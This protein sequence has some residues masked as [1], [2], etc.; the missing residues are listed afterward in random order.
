MHVCIM[1]HVHMCVSCTS[2]CVMK[3]AYN[4]YILVSIPISL[5]LPRYIQPFHPSPPGCM[6]VDLT[7]PN[8]HHVPSTCR[9]GVCTGKPVVVLIPSL[10]P[11]VPST[12]S[13]TC[14]TT[15]NTCIAGYAPSY[16]SY[17]DNCPC[18][19]EK[20]SK[21]STSMQH[22]CAAD[23]MNTVD[24]ANDVCYNTPPDSCT[25]TNPYGGGDASCGYGVIKS[26]KNRKCPQCRCQFVRGACGI[27]NYDDHCTPSQT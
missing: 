20:A 2:V 25:A 26:K 24:A 4:V 14:S 27:G 3:A 19:C 16:G 22:N 13:H 23:C 11:S 17:D 7:S 8:V 1:C 10:S 18:T 12:N 21:A 6:D 9:I 5:F 15:S